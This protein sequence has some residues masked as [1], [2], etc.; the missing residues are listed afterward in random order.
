VQVGAHPLFRRGEGAGAGKGLDLSLDLPLTLSEATLGAKV[1]VPT[2]SG[3]VE[4]VVPPSSPSGR[5]LRVRGKGLRDRSGKQGDLYAVVKIVPPEADMLSPDE[6]ETLEDIGRR[7][8]DPRSG[9]PW[10]T[11]L[12][13]PGERP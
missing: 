12:G 8:P 5:R 4:I 2:L 11:A 3:A 9:E 10:R 6:R 13:A 1:A 7:T